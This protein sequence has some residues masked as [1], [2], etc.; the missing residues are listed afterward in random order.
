MPPPDGGGVWR[1][2]QSE[3]V[4]E[5][6]KRGNDR[7]NGEPTKHRSIPG[8]RKNVATYRRHTDED[9]ID[10]GRGVVLA[11]GG[12][13]RRS[14]AVYGSG[15]NGGGFIH[16]SSLWVGSSSIKCRFG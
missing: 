11:D 15:G 6:R 1:R 14:H 16:V 8:G 12:A 10:G 2:D 7:V 9:D 5:S 13:H 4:R 3:R